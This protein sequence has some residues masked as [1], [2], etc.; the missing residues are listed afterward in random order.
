M[1]NIVNLGSIIES[2][3]EKVKIL[4]K[5]KEE[6]QK[7]LEEYCL[8]NKDK[9]SEEGICSEKHVR[10]IESHRYNLFAGKELE[11]EKVYYEENY[12]SEF[13]F[14]YRVKYIESDGS[15]SIFTIYPNEIVKEL[16]ENK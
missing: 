2:N 6:L 3:T 1:A 12:T 4:V 13:A 15:H 14:D 16:K 7:L 8:A 9:F 5:S 11:A 10:K